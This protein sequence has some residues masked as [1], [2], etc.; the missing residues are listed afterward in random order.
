MNKFAEIELPDPTS[1]CFEHMR[2]PETGEELPAKAAQVMEAGSKLFTEHG[3]GA[4]SMDQV[5]KAAGVSKATVYAHFQSKEQLF[6]A[7]V[8]AACLSYADNVMPEVRDAP[9]MRAALTRIGRSIAGF[10]MAPRT[11][12]IYRVIV[13]EGPRFPDLARRYYETG[14]RTFKRLLTQY[15]TE[16]MGKGLLKMEDPR[17]AADQ[18]CGMVRGPLYMQ[19]LLNVQDDPD[20]LQVDVVVNGAVEVFLRSYGPNSQPAV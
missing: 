16:A 4:V 17:L 10:L 1:A 13:A 14:P 20:A 7:I 15:L 19:V 18:F 5:A 2:D 9:D 3:F 11:M 8:R 6:V 12:A